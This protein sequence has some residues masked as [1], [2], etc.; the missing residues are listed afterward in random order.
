MA[1]CNRIE[2]MNKEL[3]IA[4]CDRIGQCVP[5]IRFIDFDRGQLSASGERPPVEWPC[6]LL[7]IDYTNCR[8]LAVEVNTQLVMADITLRVAFPPAGETHN[9]APEK[10]RDMA[11]QMLDTVE[12]LHDALQGETLGDTVSTLSRSRATMQTRSNKIVVFN[13]I[14]STTF[15]E[16]K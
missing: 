10:V 1:Y 11:L 5:E 15:Q 4:L 3:F 7:S 12:K 16:V 6:C 9:H 14:Y 13:L 2:A 8:D